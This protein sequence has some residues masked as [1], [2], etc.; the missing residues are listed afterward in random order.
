MTIAVALRPFDSSE[1]AVLHECRNTF[2][3][4]PPYRLKNHPV[5]KYDRPRF[6]DARGFDARSYLASLVRLGAL[7]GPSI[8]IVFEVPRRIGHDHV[9]AEHHQRAELP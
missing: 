5:V 9:V 6:R 7:L 8:G 3:P 4:G 2:A 1:I